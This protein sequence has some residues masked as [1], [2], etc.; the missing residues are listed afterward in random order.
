MDKTKSQAYNF[1]FEAIP[2]LFHSQ[3]NDFMKHLEKDGIKFLRFWWDHV[4]DKMGESQRIPW[5]GLEFS[6]EEVDATTKLVWITLPKPVN[7]EE[8]YLGALAEYQGFCSA[9]FRCD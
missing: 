3:T 9:A 1:T 7:D 6:V 5:R 2:I 4:G 8:A